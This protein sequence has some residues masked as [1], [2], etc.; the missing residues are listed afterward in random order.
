MLALVAD[1]VDQRLESLAAKPTCLPYYR[2]LPASR[3]ANSRLPGSPHGWLIARHEPYEIHE[4]L[5]CFIWT[6]RTDLMDQV[7][8]ARE[9]ARPKSP[10][11][12]WSIQE[13]QGEYYREFPRPAGASEIFAAI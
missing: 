1:E 10:A 2:V 3:F 6:N 5:G 4:P 9:L 7:A 12:W 8:A 13:G 11:S